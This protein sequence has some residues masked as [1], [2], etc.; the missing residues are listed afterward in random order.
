MI[1]TTSLHS[2]IDREQRACGHRNPGVL[3]MTSHPLLITY[4]NAGARAVLTRLHVLDGS[5]GMPNEIM[6]FC[7]DLLEALDDR[8][9]MNMW[10]PFELEREVS[11]AG[12]WICLRGLGLPPSSAIDEPRI[13]ILMEERGPER[14]GS[15]FV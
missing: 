13:C 9:D 10:T 3:I 5:L 8:S 6:T 7:L 11:I 2:D 15:S 4:M 1:V 14:Q 12:T